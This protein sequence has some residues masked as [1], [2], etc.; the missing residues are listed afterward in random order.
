MKM[1]SKELVQWQQWARYGSV[2]AKTEAEKDSFKRFC[3]FT[4]KCCICRKSLDSEDTVQSKPDCFF[5]H[6]KKCCSKKCCWQL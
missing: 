1:N 3:E 6:H 2:N 5:N 4:D